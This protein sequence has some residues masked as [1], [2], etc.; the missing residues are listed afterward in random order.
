MVAEAKLGNSGYRYPRVMLHVQCTRSD[1]GLVEPA[2]ICFGS[3]RVEV[4]AV[5]DRWYGG[6]Q[7]WWKVQ[8][9]EGLYIVRLDE[10]GG[11]WELAAVVGEWS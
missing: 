1:T 10:P 2:V 11:A 7:R 8:T 5:V 3:R 9:A 4:Q 6:N